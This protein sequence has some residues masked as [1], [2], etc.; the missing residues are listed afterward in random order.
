MQD[1]P[2]L[3]VQNV[4]KI[5][6]LW[7]SPRERF[8]FGLWSQIP[9]WAPRRLR[10][11]AQ[12]KKRALGQ[13]FRA[14]A[15]ISL[16][17]RRG[18]VI[19][20]LGRNG[21]GKSTLLQIIAGTLSPTSGSVTTNGR[22]TALLELG[23]GFDPEF[24]GRENVFLNAAILGFPR[25][26]TEERMGDI[27]EFSELAEFIDQ[28]V[29]TYSS[30]MSVR[31]AFA[32][33]VLLDPQ[34]LIVDEALAVGDVFFQQKC[35]RH[36]QK[37]V[38]RGVSVL[39]A[40]HDFRA[41]YQFCDRAVI[42]NQ[43]SMVFEGNAAEAVKK[44]NYLVGHQS[45]P[46]GGPRLSTKPDEDRQ[47]RKTKPKTESAS[48]I[49][50][51][52][53]WPEANFFTAVGKEDNDRS[54][55]AQCVSYCVLD[56]DRQPTTVFEQGATAK[57]FFE[58]LL[59]EDFDTLSGGFSL[60][61]RFGDL[62]HAKHAIQS[63]PFSSLPYGQRGKRIQCAAEVLLDIE[64]GQYIL[65]FGLV[66]I[67]MQRSDLV[68]STSLDMITFNAHSQRLCGTKPLCVITVNLKT[69]YT[70]LQLEHYGL[71]NLPSRV[72]CGNVIDSDA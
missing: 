5:Y 19:G 4:S 23:S 40:T 37:L 55:L 36:M 22:I 24:T 32:V 34:I 8:R 41:V 10:H 44:F 30:G 12:A 63:G 3:K 64:P 42:L 62:I 9:A 50:K 26:E 46:A 70:G 15:H 61:D 53:H 38:E 11:L 60:K 66:A 57:L 1:E 58:F 17:I 7:K 69:S 43:G 29:K 16:E 59:H 27:L 56:Q 33:Q 72:L 21:S 35:Y 48:P 6:H 14:L 52:L 71:A 25:Q 68:N 65:E 39:L 28:P 13:D 51:E 45:R 54:D 49:S 2:V 67:S 18:E 47:I 20:I 31:L